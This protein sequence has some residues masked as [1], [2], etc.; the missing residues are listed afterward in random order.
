[1]KSVMQLGRDQWS[2]ASLTDLPILLH[3]ACTWI[4]FILRQV[5]LYSYVRRITVWGRANRSHRLHS[6]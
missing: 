6:F 1:M 2:C 3:H 4:F 5:L